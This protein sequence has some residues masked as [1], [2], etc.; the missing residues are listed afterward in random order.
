MDLYKVYMSGSHSNTS[1][2]LAKNAKVATDKY[3]ELLR[4][5]NAKI[6]KYHELTS[7]IEHLPLITEYLCKREEIIPTL[8]PKIEFR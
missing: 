7:S 4:A 5:R 3:R 8:E 1:Y 6:T 2:I